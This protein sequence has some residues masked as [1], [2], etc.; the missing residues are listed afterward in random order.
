MKRLCLIVMLLLGS[1]LNA[2]ADKDIYD[3][4]A[5]HPRGDAALQADTEACSQAVG[6]PQNGKPTPR[7]YK[8]CMLGRGLGFGLGSVT[9]RPARGSVGLLRS[10]CVAP[11]Q[12]GTG[13]GHRVLGV[14]PRAERLADHDPPRQL[15]S[16][17]EIAAARPR[18]ARNPKPK[19]HD[20]H[21]INHHYSRV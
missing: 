21:A 3:D 18:L 5:K 2:H 11:D 15:S 14:S 10:V 8:R 13:L 12:R 17:Q 16:A 6:A 1:A 20:A 4:I 9:L 7:A 19:E